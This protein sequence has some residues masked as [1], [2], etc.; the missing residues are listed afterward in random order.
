MPRRISR[1]EPI[2]PT[3]F[4]AVS[5]TII[6]LML[7]GNRRNP[8]SAGEKPRTFCMYCVIT[9][10]IPYAAN[11]AA[12]IVMIAERVRA[13]AEELEV[14]HGVRVPAFAEDKCRQRRTRDPEQ[15]QDLP[16]EPARMRTFNHGKRESPDRRDE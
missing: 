9:S 12:K 13:V 6:R 4:P 11:K 2:T 14:H 5:D 15:R 10:N 1:R 3:S 16:R 7:Y 8:A